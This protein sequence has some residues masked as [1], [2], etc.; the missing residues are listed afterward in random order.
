VISFRIVAAVFIFALAM[1]CSPRKATDHGAGSCDYLSDG[2]GRLRVDV[3][4]LPEIDA[5]KIPAQVLESIRKCWS[6]YPYDGPQYNLILRE[7][8]VFSNSKYYVVFV[9]D[10]I[11]DVLIVFLVD[12]QRGVED[13]YQFGRM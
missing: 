7:A 11:T 1:A 3:E 8:R 13:A 4:A 2:Y 5:K 9:P 6:V 10:G 12:R